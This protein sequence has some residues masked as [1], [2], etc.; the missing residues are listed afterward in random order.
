MKFEQQRIN[1]AHTLIQI[2]KYLTPI[3]CCQ[4]ALF[5]LIA[6]KDPLQAPQVLY[7]VLVSPLTTCQQL[8]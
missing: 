2:E 4:A 8:L 7:S 1:G 5:V 6:G 3:R